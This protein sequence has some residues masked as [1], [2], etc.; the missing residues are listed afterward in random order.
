MCTLLF[1]F[2]TASS[3]AAHFLDLALLATIVRVALEAGDK[4]S[5][6]VV[7]PCL[8]ARCSKAAAISILYV[9]ISATFRMSGEEPLEQQLCDSTALVMSGI[10]SNAVFVDA[11]E[12]S[13]SV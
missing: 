6:D 4:S 11:A 9:A 5:Y 3:E 7:T 10:L 2:T 1:A 12:Q 13:I 8:F